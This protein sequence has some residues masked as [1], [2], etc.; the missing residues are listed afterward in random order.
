MKTSIKKLAELQA[1]LKKV[2]DDVAA[3][4]LDRAKA[5]EKII[6]LRGSMDELIK[7]LQSKS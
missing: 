2:H 3:G 7:E 4:K 5:A 1:Q 6:E